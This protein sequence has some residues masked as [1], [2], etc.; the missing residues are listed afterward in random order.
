[1]RVTAIL[2]R[3][4]LI[5]VL[6]FGKGIGAECLPSMGELR[7]VAEHT[8]SG[9]LAGIALEPNWKF[10]AWVETWSI[11]VVEPRTGEEIAR[12]VLPP[13]LQFD[14]RPALSA[15]G[16]LAIALNDG[17]VRV[18]NVWTSQEVGSFPARLA[19]EC[20]ALSEDGRLLAAVGAEGALHIWDVLS[21]E[22]RFCFSEFTPLGFVCPTAFSRDGRW[23]V[24]L[25]WSGS[26]F[27]SL[28]W[29]LSTGQL[30]RL[31]PGP[32]TLLH[33]GRVVVVLRDV[34]TTRVEIW[35]NPVGEKLASIRFPTGWQ[36]DQVAF[37]PS[38]SMFVVA[39]A[40]GSIRIWDGRT[41]QEIATLPSCI[42]TDPQTGE[43]ARGLLLKFSPDGEEIF[44]G[45]WWPSI[46]RGVASLW[47]IGPTR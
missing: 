4:V 6:S 13:H 23:L 28:V 34:P 22:S 27:I 16:L 32:V 24:A 42:R 25:A 46:N 35:E 21:G 30:A 18:W 38:S 8:F 20:V 2:H 11:Y 17:T 26:S 39:L 19:G 36:V 14:G 47:C 37:H 7:S 1:M 33:D 29:D 45:I 41:G 44:L 15:N 40:D 3:V 10:L 9:Y 31:F 5:C 43:I 12:I